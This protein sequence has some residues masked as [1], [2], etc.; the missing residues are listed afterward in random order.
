VKTWNGGTQYKCFKQSKMS[1]VIISNP[2]KSIIQPNQAGNQLTDLLEGH[3]LIAANLVNA[4]KPG[5]DS[6]VADT[7]ERWS[8]N[9]DEFAAFLIDANPNWNKEELID[10]LH[11]HLNMTR[12][13]AVA[14][15]QGD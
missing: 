6:T 5:N 12:A 1:K 4:A 3:I 15:L 10:M 11:N 9:A 14:R 13:E 8:D 7:D 2:I